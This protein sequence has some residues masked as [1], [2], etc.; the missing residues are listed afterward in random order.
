MTAVVNVRDLTDNEFVRA[1]KNLVHS[2]CQR[3]VPMLEG[4]K[5]SSGADYDD[6][7]QVGMMGLL[8][9][10]DRFNMDYGLKFSTYAVPM[11]IGE[12][13]RFL[14]D[15]NMVKTPRWI[16][17][18]YN[19]MRKLELEGE[20][21][22]VIA[23]ALE[24]TEEQVKTLLSYQ[25]QFRSLSDVVFNDAAGSMEV[26]LLDTLQDDSTMEEDVVN[27][28]IVK[29]FLATLSERERLIWFEYHHSG[30]RQSTLSK[31]HGVSQVQI[32]RILSKIEEKAHRFGVVK[33]YAKK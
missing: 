28:S 29:D 19:R 21:I 8:K 24:I 3:Y 15:N 1:H 12:I 31:R 13:R 16:K 11:I 30:D 9:A 18:L 25:P 14:R 17:E 26:T 32:S 22:P 2:V 23:A 7:F 27:H 6:L 33:G 4:I 5:H 10:R 20:E